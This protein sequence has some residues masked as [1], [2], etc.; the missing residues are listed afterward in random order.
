[1][2]R[3]VA[4]TAVGVLPPV[5]AWQQDIEVLRQVVVGALGGPGRGLDEG[6]GEQHG[7]AA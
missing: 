4:R 1:M 7:G 3:T 6:L 5:I 2:I